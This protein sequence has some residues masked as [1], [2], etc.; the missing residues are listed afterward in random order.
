MS[1]SSNSSTVY[2]SS[3][4][5]LSAEHLSSF[6]HST[7]H[8]WRLFRS[9]LRSDIN[10][11]PFG[12]QFLR[13]LGQATAAAVPNAAVL[14]DFLDQL[15]A[16]VEEQKTSKVS[17]PIRNFDIGPVAK[18]YVDENQILNHQQYDYQYSENCPSNC[19]CP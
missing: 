19:C 2:E 14:I 5:N 13:I 12:P 8:T 17:I 9:R 6:L 10:P 15:L 18:S 1:E 16:Q 4:L 3:E 7:R 11:L